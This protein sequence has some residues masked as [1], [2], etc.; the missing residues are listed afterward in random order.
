MQKG[1]RGKYWRTGLRWLD[2]KQHTQY[3]WEQD[4]FFYREE[5]LH[6][7]ELAFKNISSFKRSLFTGTYSHLVIW[8]CVIAFIINVHWK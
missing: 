4:F 8:K 6:E 3:V 5:V 1:G 7:E 2:H